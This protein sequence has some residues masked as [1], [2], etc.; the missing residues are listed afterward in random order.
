VSDAGAF[1]GFA[2]VSCQSGWSVV[3][4]RNRDSEEWLEVKI[5][6]AGDQVGGY[7]SPVGWSVRS[8]NGVEV[9]LVIAMQLT[10]HAHKTIEGEVVR[11]HPDNLIDIVEGCLWREIKSFGVTKLLHQSIRVVE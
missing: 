5:S 2:Y 10:F 9:I 7:L 1:K 8:S 6:V 4:S 11:V 3:K